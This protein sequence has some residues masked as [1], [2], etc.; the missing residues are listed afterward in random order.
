MSD[1]KIKA[2]GVFKAALVVLVFFSIALPLTDVAQVCLRRL[3]ICHSASLL[4]AGGN[5][6]RMQQRQMGRE[7]VDRDK[8]KTETQGR[9]GRRGG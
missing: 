5:F 1:Q 7:C 2:S 4:G 6:E 3:C 8:T 9:K